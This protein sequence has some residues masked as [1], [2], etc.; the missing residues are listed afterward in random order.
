[1]MA[2]A[3]NKRVDRASR[4]LNASP[5]AIYRAFVD[6]QALAAWLPPEGMR[7]EILAFEPREGGAFEMALTYKE[8]G[9]GHGKTS[10]NAEMVKGRFG[11][12]V[13]ERRIVWLVQFESDDP[14]FAGTMRMTWEFLPVAGGTEVTIR[15]EDVPV[16]ISPEDHDEGL[17]SSLNGLARAVEV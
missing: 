11:E 17:R 3:A 4:L 6:Q 14:K 1:M 2:Q 7:G 8:A 15:A 9:Q 13:P 5:Q 16:G 10:E 12:M